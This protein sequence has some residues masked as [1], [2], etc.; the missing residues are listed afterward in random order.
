MRNIL[1]LSILLVF[2]CNCGDKTNAKEN[3]DNSDLLQ[4]QIKKV[5]NNLGNDLIIK[6]DLNEVNTDNLNINIILNKDKIVHPSH[7]KV[8]LTYLIYNVNQ[9]SKYDLLNFT[10]HIEG[11][12]NTNVSSLRITKPEIQAIN[13]AYESKLFT[14]MIKYSLSNFRMDTVFNLES[15]IANVNNRYPDDTLQADFYEVLEVFHKECLESTDSK[16]AKVTFILAFVAIRSYIENEEKDIESQK[17]SKKMIENLWEI[18][19]K[20]EKIEFAEKRLFGSVGD[21][22]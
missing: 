6:L 22:W 14:E 16:K 8:F 15:W 18:C 12:K 3:S 4:K 10:Y 17:H 19:S 1:Y 2:I 13:R 5:L 11:E 9:L 7:Q 20:G 21:N